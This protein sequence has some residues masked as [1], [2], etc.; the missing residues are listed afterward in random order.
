MST[1]EKSI[2]YVETG[3]SILIKCNVPKTTST[4]YREDEGMA[5]RMRKFAHDAAG[6]SVAHLR[7]YRTKILSLG[8]KNINGQA[9][10][11]LDVPKLILHLLNCVVH[12]GED[13]YACM[14]YVSLIY[15]QL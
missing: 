2:K 3:L 11:R 6:H 10:F 7:D 1:Q 15:M 5:K 9:V 8:Y 4:V 12:G 13:S 14:C